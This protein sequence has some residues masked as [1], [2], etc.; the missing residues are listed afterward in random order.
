[1]ACDNFADLSGSICSDCIAPYGLSVA[2][3]REITFDVGA[4]TANPSFYFIAMIAPLCFVAC[5]G[6]CSLHVAGQYALLLF[7]IVFST[8]LLLKVACYAAFESET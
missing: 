8:G 2:L 6:P 5:G 1:M 3:W 7:D 4:S